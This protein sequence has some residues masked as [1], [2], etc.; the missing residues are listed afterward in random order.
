MPTC[1]KDLEVQA[2]WWERQWSHCTGMEVGSL[3]RQKC[4]VQDGSSS[5]LMGVPL[6]PTAPY[7][8]SYN[9]CLGTFKEPFWSISLREKCSLEIT[10]LIAIKS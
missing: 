2:F 10:I 4:L 3:S 9:L 1:S 7:V 5:G 8:K 6:K